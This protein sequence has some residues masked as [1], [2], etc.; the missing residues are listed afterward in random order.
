MKKLVFV[1]GSV[2]A[3]S[4]AAIVVPA[5]ADETEVSFAYV[6]APAV[7]QIVV[8]QPLG[9]L[10]VRGWDRPE[11]RIEATKHAPDHSGLDRL[12]V[13]V[14]LKDGR[15][16]IVTGVR[17][18]E[19]LRSVPASG[20][21][22]IDLAVDA[23]AGAQ[24]RARTFDGD[25]DAMGLRAGAELSSTGGAIYAT[26]IDGTVHSNATRGRQRLA[27][28]RGD[29][30]AEGLRGDVELDS[31][32]GAILRASIV[33]GAVTA[34]RIRSG[35][36]EVVV[37]RGDVQFG[38]AMPVG[39]RWIVRAPAGN[40]RLL[41]DTAAVSLSLRANGQLRV[42]ASVRA[43]LQQHELHL[44]RPGS[45]RLVDAQASGDLELIERT[46]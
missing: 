9:R 7:E 8:E 46:R 32:E 17:V 40:I 2:V 29:V 24:V 28:I 25:L 26:D 11:V 3:L 20:G 13:R 16:E 5:F 37:A 22:T 33:E 23:P 35:A 1:W 27:A 12:R 36:V 44:A 21:Y 19:S 10:T 18:G 14:E 31:I 34:R 38:G 15:V 6:P 41:L 30:E 4:L 42:P 45:A 43:G 39:A